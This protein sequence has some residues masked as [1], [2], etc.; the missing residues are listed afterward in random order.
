MGKDNRTHLLISPSVI[1]PALLNLFN[2]SSIISPN[3][4]NVSFILKRKGTQSLRNSPPPQWVLQS[5][6]NVCSPFQFFKVW[7]WLLPFSP[8][9]SSH[10]YFITPG[11]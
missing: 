2:Q 5:Q 1:C 8:M 4:C 3:G 9:L 10:F 6:A 7:Q 11:S